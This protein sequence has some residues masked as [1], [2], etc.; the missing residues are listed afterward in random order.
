MRVPLTPGLIKAK[1]GFSIVQLVVVMCIV[2]VTLA[3]GIPAYNRTLRPTAELNSAAR[4][5]F[6]DIQLA[7][8][9]AV[10][11]NVRF[12]LDFDS[13][14]D[15]YIVFRDTDGDYEY[16]DGTQNIVKRVK[17]SEGFGYSHVIFDTNYGD[18]DGIDFNSNSFSF[19][20]RGLPSAKGTV[21]LR[22]SKNS[23]EG[24]KVVVNT[25]GGV[26]IEEYSP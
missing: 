26:R 15:D 18:G 12:G 7:R 20:T 4:H 25:M 22:N 19:S 5:L 2:S 16:N 21:F 6:S 8:L 9:Q 11:E 23:P 14:S 10:T 24:R 3:I 13:T 1:S 17:F